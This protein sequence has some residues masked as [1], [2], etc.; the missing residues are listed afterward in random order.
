M[1]PDESASLTKEAERPA[2]G[3]AHWSKSAARTNS[4]ES[5]ITAWTRGCCRVSISLLVPGVRT[6]SVS[7]GHTG[8]A[9]F[10]PVG[11]KVGVTCM[12]AGIGVVMLTRGDG[13]GM[14][15]GRA[16]S[17]RGDGVGAG[18]FVLTR[19]ENVGVGTV[20]LPRGDGTRVATTAGGSS[21]DM[22]GPSVEDGPSQDGLC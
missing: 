21:I 1:A 19:G 5:R 13:V 8:G 6:R 7:A 4:N 18:R 22:V 20:R 9:T 17:T 14:G 12:G 3:R 15:V 10:A 2:F 11:T 16:M